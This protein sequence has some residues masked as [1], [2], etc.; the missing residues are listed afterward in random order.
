[1]AL[2]SDSKL[3]LPAARP[4]TTRPAPARPQPARWAL[5]VL[6]GPTLSYRTLGPA[7]D[8]VSAAVTSRERPALGL[9]AQV[10]LR[11]VLSG[12][13]SVAG[14]LG[15]QEYATRFALQVRTPRDST[16]QAVS[17]RDSYR[18]LTLP[19]QVGYA[20]RGTRGR[21]AT[22]VLAGAEPAWYQGGRST[23]S[24][25][26]STG[27]GCQQQTYTSA[28]ASPY[29]PWTLGLSLGLDL[30]YRLGRGPV[31]RWYLVAQPTGR[32]VLTPFVRP[33]AAGYLP[34]RQPFSFGVLM[35]LAWKLR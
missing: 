13:W 7:A 23:G 18:L 15:Y 10:Q 24:R 27:C 25:P 16:Y 9:G 22:A 30:R 2:A 17:Q 1:M 11:R 33:E 8:L 19:L 21:L 29:R 20:L 4:D 31:P 32:Y 6:A 34:A 5:L 28:A 3:S 14:G 35:G 26:D 12:R